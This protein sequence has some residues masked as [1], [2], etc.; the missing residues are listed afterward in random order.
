MFN[1]PPPPNFRGLNP[2]LPVIVYYRNLPHWRQEGATYFVTFRLDDALPQ[3]KLQ[4]LHALRIQ[5][6]ATHPSPRSEQDWKDYAREVTQHAERWMDAGYGECVFREPGAAGI[7]TEAL[8]HFQNQRYFTSCYTVMP[9]HCHL[10]IQPFEGHPLEKILQ[11]CKGYV[12]YKVNRQRNQTGSLW[13]E[14]SYDQIVRDGEHLWRVVQYIGNN[15]GRAGLP[16]DRWVR[17]IH[18]EWQRAGWKFV[19]E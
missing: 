4:L 19:D 13:Q 15:P 10:V 7:L 12:A 1:L 3:E 11:V 17:W 6:E 18:P 8:V 14:E 2:D 5:W 9:N 16:R